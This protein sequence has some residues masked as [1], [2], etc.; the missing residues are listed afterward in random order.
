[1]MMMIK[2]WK[3]GRMRE[4]TR[5]TVPLIC[6]FNGFFFISLERRRQRCMT[7][8]NVPILPDRPTLFTG[9]DSHLKRSLFHRDMTRM[10]IYSE[11]AEGA[12][13]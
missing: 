12:L 9:T 7:T 1:M 13:L 2:G 11:S 4:I 5:V 3:K 6:A 8:F 10:M